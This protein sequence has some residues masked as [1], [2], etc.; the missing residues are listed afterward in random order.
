MPFLCGRY[1]IEIIGIKLCV[2]CQ[3][4]PAALLIVLADEAYNP[5]TLRIIFAMLPH[6]HLNHYPASIFD[7]W[8]GDSSEERR[9][10]EKIIVVR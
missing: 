5:L 9:K 8:V 3:R 1:D 4:M 6:P 7:R 10:N 2:L